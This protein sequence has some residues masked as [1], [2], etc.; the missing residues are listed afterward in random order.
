MNKFDIARICHEVNAAY[1]RSLGDD[2]QPTWEDSEEWMRESAVDGVK[3]HLD[4][5]DV[6]PE[7]S[8]ENWMALKEKEGWKYGP[9]KNVE[10]KEHPCFVEF[11]DLP[12]EQKAKDYIFRQI[13]HSLKEHIK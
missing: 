9:E 1:C 3:F 4:N 6:G 13:V 2:S 12:I 7:A 10:K 11:D 8:H 5:P